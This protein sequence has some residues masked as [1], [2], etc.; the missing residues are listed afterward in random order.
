MGD[1]ILVSNIYEGYLSPL[2]LTGM[3]LTSIAAEVFVVNQML[4]ILYCC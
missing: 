3:L 4:M 1:L 2:S